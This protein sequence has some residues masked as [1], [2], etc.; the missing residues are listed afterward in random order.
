M[1]NKLKSWVH[2]YFIN[3]L[4][5]Q[6]RIKH[7]IDFKVSSSNN[8]MAGMNKLEYIDCVFN[9]VDGKYNVTDKRVAQ[10][11]IETVFNEYRTPSVLGSYFKLP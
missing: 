9:A 10:K 4:D 2:F 6:P 1:E 5:F 3:H 11:Y 7:I 8:L